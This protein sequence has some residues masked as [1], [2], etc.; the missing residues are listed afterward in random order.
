[1]PTLTIV[2]IAT[3]PYKYKTPF[4]SFI[5]DVIDRTHGVTISYTINTNTN[6]TTTKITY[7]LICDTQELAQTV[8]TKL[9]NGENLYN[10]Y[11]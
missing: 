6:L 11:A 4:L 7:T 5:T 8:M 3:I 9:R 2:D 10:H 1:M